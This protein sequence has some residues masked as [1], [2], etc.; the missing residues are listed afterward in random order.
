MPG[1]FFRAGQYF[2]QLLEFQLELRQR[3]DAGS[4]LL[5]SE[6]DPLPEYVDGDDLLGAHRC[7]KGLPLLGEALAGGDI[8][9]VL[10]LEAA[11][12]PAASAGDLRRIERQVLVLSQ[13]QV[14]GG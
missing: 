13:A 5:V 14:D 12:Q 7:S 8:K 6:K 9:V 1:A 4:V 11:E 10:V 2:A 3:N